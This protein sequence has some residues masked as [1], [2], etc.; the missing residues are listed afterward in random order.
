MNET[1]TYKNAESNEEVKTIHE[2]HEAHHEAHGGGHECCHE[3]QHDNHHNEQHGEHHTCCHENKH[4]NHH[5]GQHAQHECCHGGSNHQHQRKQFADYIQQDIE[6]LYKERV[7]ENF[8]EK[9]LVFVQTKPFLSIGLVFVVS[10]LLGW[11]W[12]A[13]RKKRQACHHIHKAKICKNA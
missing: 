11:H 1:E 5:E 7:S 8:L 13:H 6:D 10:T 12:G 2:E 3:E 9:I 4:E